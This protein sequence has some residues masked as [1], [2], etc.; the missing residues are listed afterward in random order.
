[1]E[2][3]VLVSGRTLASSWAAVAFVDN[4]QEAE[5]SLAVRPHPNGRASFDW[6][7]MRG[8][9][10]YHN[11]PLSVRPPGLRYLSCTDFS[12]IVMKQHSSFPTPMDQCVFIRG[13]RCQC[14][15]VVSIG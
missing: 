3:L 5:I 14:A 8:T 7:K 2:D 12:I 10:S 13:F 4:S 11:S 1:M 15:L 6:S 9:V